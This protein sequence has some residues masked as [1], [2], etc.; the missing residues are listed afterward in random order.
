METSFSPYS[1]QKLQK[2]HFR[3][4]DFQGHSRWPSPQV[5]TAAAQATPAP[6]PSQTTNKHR[7]KISHPRICYFVT[8]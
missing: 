8:E 1:A 7:N 3:L 5:V 4:P 6:A 2:S